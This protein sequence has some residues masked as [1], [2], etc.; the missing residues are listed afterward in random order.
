MWTLHIPPPPFW[1]KW[2]AYIVIFTHSNFCAHVQNLKRLLMWFGGG[3]LISGISNTAVQIWIWR[4]IYKRA[5]SCLARHLALWEVFGLPG[6]SMRV[7]LPKGHRP[8]EKGLK[9]PTIE[10]NQHIKSL[11]LQ[12]SWT[13]LIN[14]WKYIC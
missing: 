1:M 11:I 14:R 7:G 5:S 3:H 10:S 9:I 6:I 8:G 12:Y 4:K 13:L 2:G